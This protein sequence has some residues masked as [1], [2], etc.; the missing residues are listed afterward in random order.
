MPEHF[1]NAP[2]RRAVARAAQSLVQSGGHAIC[3]AAAVKSDLVNQI[4]I[5]P[6]RVHV[7][8]LAA[9]E[10]LFHQVQ[11]P[12]L[13]AAVRRKYGVPPGEYLLSLSAI[14]SRKNLPQLVRCFRW[15][16]SETATPAAS[17]GRRAK[18]AG[19]RAFT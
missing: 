7:I 9:S 17:R 8:P 19:R 2:V 12:T 15:L 10:A 4:G 16:Q 18:A 5:D 1:P 6:D 14:D 11:D 3:T 13:I